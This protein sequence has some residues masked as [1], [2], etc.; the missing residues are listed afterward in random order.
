MKSNKKSTKTC[1]SELV[2]KST[3]ALREEIKEDL[4]KT[5]GSLKELLENDDRKRQET[6]NS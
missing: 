2:C 3:G 1:K 4:S 6:K 5:D